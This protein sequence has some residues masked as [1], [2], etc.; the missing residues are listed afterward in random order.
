MTDRLKPVILLVGD[1]FLASEKYKSILK[2]VEGAH[3]GD[4]ARQTFHLSETPLEAVL[5]Q[6]RTLPFLAPA[7]VFRIDDLAKLKKDDVEM[8]EAYLEQPSEKSILI[9]QAQTLKKNDALTK[10]IQKKGDAF[11]LEVERGQSESVL[12]IKE[13]LKAFGKIMSPG[14]MARLQED[15]GEFP[16]FLD[17]ML[18]RLIAYSGDQKQID[19]TMINLFQEEFKTINVFDLT[20]EI[21]FIGINCY[22]FDS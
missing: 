16:V 2:T 15:C 4:V 8:L 10:L 7:Q 1:P 9:F 3:P 18:D 20:N 22:S 13:K 19:E 21:A 11:F 6:A 14:A 5:A 17:S 12:F